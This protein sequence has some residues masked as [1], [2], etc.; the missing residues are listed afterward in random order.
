MPGNGRR[1]SSTVQIPGIDAF[2][3]MITGFYAQGRRPMPWREVI[4][5]YSVVV[6]EIMLQQTQVPLVTEK[7]P[8]FIRQFPDFPS[9]SRGSPR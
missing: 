9:L 5:P 1:G 7:F 8:P 3:R 2:I 6:S 4:T